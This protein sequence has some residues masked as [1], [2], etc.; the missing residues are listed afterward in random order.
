MANDIRSNAS[1]RALFELLSASRSVAL[2]GERSNG[3]QAFAMEVE[4]LVD[5]GFRVVPV[6]R[7]DAEILGR[8]AFASIGAIPERVDIV[9]IAD[10]ESASVSIADDAARIGAKALWLQRGVVSPDMVQRAVDLGLTVVVDR[11]IG[12]A[13]VDFGIMHPSSTAL[14]D[15][16]DEA[17][18]ESFPA[19]D[20]PPWSR[21]RP[22]GPRDRST[23]ASP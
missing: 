9:D 7:R 3:S 22:G 15:A 11:D 17:G 5:A 21:V 12:Q 19:S 4:I 8:R 6:S 14:Y 20:P 18:R 10:S 16:V 23:D 2:V 13:V 1:T